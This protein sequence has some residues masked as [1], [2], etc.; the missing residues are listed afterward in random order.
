MQALQA[1]PFAR[2]DTLLADL[3]PA[4]DLRFVDLSIGEPKHPAPQCVLDALA[5][6]LDRVSQYPPTTGSLP[7]RSAIANWANRRFDLGKAPLDPKHNVLPANGTREALFAITQLVANPDKTGLIGMP[8]PFYQIYEGAAILAGKEPIFFNSD[9]D[10]RL[11]PNWR[12]IEESVWAQVELLY[13][14]T[15]DNPAGT[16]LPL[17]ELVY[18]IQMARK[19]NF[20]LV[21]DECY[22][23]LY[24]DPEK[25]SPGILQACLAA[26]NT[27]YKNV[28]AVHSLSKRSNLPGLRSGFVA[29]DAEI[30]KS[31]SLYRTYHGSA[32]PGPTQMASIAAWQDE[33]H[34]EANREI[35][36][37]KYEAVLPLLR[38]HFTFETPDAGFYLWLKTPICELETTQRLYRDYA[39]KVVP[40][41]FFARSTHDG[42]P[43]S[44]RIRL[45]L[46]APIEEC[47]EGV[48]RLLKFRATLT[49][50]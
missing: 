2:L 10:S 11:Q 46:V 45:A 32:M 39:L 50:I 43:G 34:V 47:I 49:D 30:I 33:T 3:I 23:E 24:L 13:I 14:C 18:L 4:A 31:F 26:G 1:Y 21:S 20:V 22:C 37:R 40:G 38:D 44:N 6:N 12:K 29:G 36:R 17:S 42:N 19:H 9:E 41:S 7:L 16:S 15:P 8:N 5:N 27:E 48:Q 35:Y 25:P 28:L